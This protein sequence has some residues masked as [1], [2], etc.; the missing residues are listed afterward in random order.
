VIGDVIHGYEYGKIEGSFHPRDDWTYTPDRGLLTTAMAYKTSSAWR[1]RIEL[2]PPKKHQPTILLGQVASGD[3]VVD[4]PTNAFF[5]SVYQKWPKTKAVEMEG[6]GVAAAITQARDGGK[7][8]GFLMIRGISDIP[9]P[10][11][12]NSASDTSEGQRGTQERDNWKPYAAE[13]AAAVTVG[14]IAEGLPVPPRENN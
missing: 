4:D 13:V 5:A 12:I 3:K 6:A 9:R 11:Q 7:V 14:L 2:A 1:K 8:V 10:H